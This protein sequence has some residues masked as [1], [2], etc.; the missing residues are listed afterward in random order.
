MQSLWKILF[1]ISLITL[2]ICAHADMNVN[3]TTLKNFSAEFQSMCSY[4]QFS[5]TVLVAIDDK[6]IFEKACGY[7]N[8]SF[9]NLNSL[10]TKFNLG[11]VGKI[12]TSVA[13]AQLIQA[14]KITLSTSLSNV[15]PKWLPQ[16]ISNKITID[17]LL[18]HAAGLGNF[19]NNNKWKEGADN[20]LFINTDNYKS[21][22]AEDKQLF[23]PGTS[24]SYSNNGY[25]ILGAIIEAAT[26]KSYINYIK[27]EIFKPADMKDT[28][29]YRMDEPVI[30]R[31]DGYVYL[32]ELGKC[33]WRN[34]YY[35]V[36]FNGTSAGGIYSTAGD[37]FKFSRALHEYKFLN[38]PLTQQILSG[39]IVTR[40]KDIAVDIAI[41]SY[42]INNIEIPENFSPYGFAGAWNSLGFAVWQNPTL[43]GHTGGTAGVSS[44][45]ATSSD[46]KYTIIILSNLTGS[47]PILL[48]KKIR[49]LLGFSPEIMN[50]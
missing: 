12:F 44:F 7:A 4:Q 35:Q 42:R 16:D 5:G 30:N 18:I 15:L 23:K 19:M 21:I 38:Q 14:N 2:S 47:G 26:K 11:S 1:S 41:K 22:I 34:N 45:F 28:D 17:Q 43:V 3:P 46:G 31:A 37:L 36:P 9:N 39:E 29:I 40:S 48:Y 49:L 50:Y 27:Q 8:R 33:R 24:Q 20:A 13:I 6:I 25:I 10:N 32:C